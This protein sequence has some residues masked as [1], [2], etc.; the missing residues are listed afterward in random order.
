PCQAE[1]KVNVI[2]VVAANQ[3]FAGEQTA[4]TD[5]LH[6]ESNSRPVLSFIQQPDLQV[7]TFVLVVL[8]ATEIWVIAVEPVGDVGVAYRSLQPGQRLQEEMDLVVGPNGRNAE[9]E[10]TFV[11]HARG[12]RLQQTDVTEIVVA[13]KQA[14]EVRCSSGCGASQADDGHDA[15]NARGEK[16]RRS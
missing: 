7:G 1:R 14:I 2:P 10:F 13:G 16:N 15:G 4:A 9:T 6:A 11:A 5:V 8:A 12:R 3:V